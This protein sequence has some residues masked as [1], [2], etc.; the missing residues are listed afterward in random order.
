V[1]AL[2]L[3]VRDLGHEVHLCTP[4]NFVEQARTLGFTATPVGVEMR[5]PRATP[6]AS[7]AP[8]QPASPPPAA[9]ATDLITDQFD[10]LLTAAQGCDIILGANAHQYAA[11]SIAE[12]QGIPYINALYSPT[13]LPDS[14][15]RKSWNARGLDRVNTNRARL[16]LPP[17]EDVLNY[18][19]TPTPWLA[20]DPTLAPTPDLTSGLPAGSIFQTGAWL[21]PDN[22]PLPP[23]LDEFLLAGSPPVYFGFGSMPTPGTTSE[24]LIRAARDAGHRV[25]LSRGWADLELTDPT[26]DCIA[27][28]DVNHAALFPRV[29]LIVHHGGAGTTVA[30]SRAGTPQ[31][32]VPMFSDQPYWAQ[33]V[34]ELGIGASVP[35]SGLSLDSLTSAIHTV[36]HG[37]DAV[38]IA[39]RASA[40]SGRIKTDGASIAARKLVQAAG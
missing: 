10:T 40:I 14:V 36:L 19:T 22:T 35:F 25:I 18:I 27:I 11:P 31:L 34:V 33:R 4:P 30:A 5:A 26:P 16:G 7:P 13:A 32:V 9:N 1:I 38:R 6:P 3:A 15:N 2:A 37:A 17:I 12:I 20:A 21:L 23:E 39:E 29:G 28:E 24:T 8:A